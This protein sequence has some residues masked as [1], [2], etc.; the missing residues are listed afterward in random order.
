MTIYKYQIPVED[1]FTLELPFNCQFLSIGQ[2]SN[3]PFIWCLVDPAQPMAKYAFRLAG[4]GHQIDVGDTI[5]YLGTVHLLSG[6]LVFHLFALNTA[7][8]HVARLLNRF[9]MT[10]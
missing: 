5:G 6:S 7:H 4:T 8:P 2:Q 10:D 9:Q 3:L 1:N